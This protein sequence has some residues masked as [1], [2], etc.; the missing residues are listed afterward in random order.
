MQRLRQDRVFHRA[1]NRR[2]G[3][4]GKQ[5]KKHQRQII[6]QKT[7]GAD[8]HDQDLGQLDR[9]DQGVLGEL[10][11]KLAAQGGEQKERQDKQQRT[12]IDQQCAVS[13]QAELVENGENQR[14]LEDVVVEGTQQLGEKERQKASFTQ[15]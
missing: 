8:R 7:A 14:L 12:Q 1:E 11:A 5:G 15:Q 9:A 10:L 6:E 3:A 2:V 13:L 4:H